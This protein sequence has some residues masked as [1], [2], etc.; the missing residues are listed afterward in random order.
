MCGRFG[1]DIPGEWFEE[2]FDIYDIPDIHRE[3]VRPTTTVAVIRQIDGEYVLYDTRWGLIDPKNMERAKKGPGDPV[4]NV[5]VENVHWYPLSNQP[6]Y[7]GERVGF[8]VSYFEE[9]PDGVRTRIGMKSRE[10]MLFG[11]VF[12]VCNDREGQ[13]VECSSIF[14]TEANELCA[15]LHPKKKRMPLI[16]E[17]E[18]WYRWLNP[19][20][21]PKSLLPI[22]KP[23]RSEPMDYWVVPEVQASLF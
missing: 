19:E 21:D 3:D 7:S 18:D 6:F 13:P 12:G 1:Q 5:K 10:I 17:R 14:T 9:W 4:I 16:L 11:G 8:A 20:T 15:P 2:E 22:M 23:Y